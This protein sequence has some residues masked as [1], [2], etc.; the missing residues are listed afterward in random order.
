VS[1]RATAGAAPVVEGAR[2]AEEVRRDAGGALHPARAGRQQRLF[3]AV[4]DETPVHVVAVGDGALDQ[5]VAEP[6]REVEVALLALT[7]PEGEHHVADAGGATAPAVVVPEAG[8]GPL[9]DAGGLEG[10][11]AGA[12]PVGRAAT[13]DLVDAGPGECREGQ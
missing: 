5:G 13:G 12:L 11:H 7:L 8:V 9:G 2:Q 1:I 10:V 6:H 3:G 4:L